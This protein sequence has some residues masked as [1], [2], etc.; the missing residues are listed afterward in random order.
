MRVIVGLAHQ[1]EKPNRVLEQQIGPSHNNHGLARVQQGTKRAG[2]HH[3]QV[4][5]E[6]SVKLDGGLRNARDPRTGSA[7]R[8]ARWTRRGC[9]LSHRSRCRLRAEFLA[10]SAQPYLIAKWPAAAQ[11]SEISISQ[12][13]EHLQIHALLL[14]K[15]GVLRQPG[16]LEFLTQ[17]AHCS[18]SLHR[19]S[20]C[21]K[22]TRGP[23][24][25]KGEARRKQ[26]PGTFSAWRRGPEKAGAT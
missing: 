17:V 20:C 5:D 21:D 15:L 18:T 8:R 11:L 10:Q 22:S 24:V 23:I 1:S 25:T 9:R 6:V 16:C 4:V 12:T 2:N 26:A 3:R 7:S 19:D 14:K 13:R